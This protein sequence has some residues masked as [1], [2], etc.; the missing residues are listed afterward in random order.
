M[1]IINQDF[2]QDLLKDTNKVFVLVQYTGYQLREDGQPL[3]IQEYS[4]VG[5]NDCHIDFVYLI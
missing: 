3:Q 2:Q 5:P 1:R 4:A